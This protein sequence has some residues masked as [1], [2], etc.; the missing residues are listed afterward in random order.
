M[1]TAEAR[2]SEASTVGSHG[3]EAVQVAID[4]GQCVGCAVCVDVCTSQA[5]AWS[6]ESLAP[7]WL[8]EKCSGCGTCEHECP[9]GA[10]CVSGATAVARGAVGRK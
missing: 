2:G 1:A 6:R 4:G 5:F 3:H 9:T 10:I 8:P 7:A